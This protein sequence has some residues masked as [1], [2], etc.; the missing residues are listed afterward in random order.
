MMWNWLVSGLASGT[1][2]ILFDG[3]PLHP[4]TDSLWQ[5]AEELGVTVFG[6]SAKYLS[7]QQKAGVRVADRLALRPLR[8]ILS[9]GSPLA[10]ESFDYLRQAIKPGV[11]ISSISGGTDIVSCFALGNPLL[12]VRRGQLQCRGLGMA[13]EVFDR[14]GRSVRDQPGELVCTRSFPSMPVGFWNDPDGRRYHAAYFERFPGVWTHGDWTLLTREGGLIIEGRSDA[15]L[16]PGGVRIGT[17]EIYRQ[18]E[19]LPQIRESV[20][21]GQRWNDDVRVV[22]FVVLRE[23]QVLDEALCHAIEETL[24]NNASPRHV[25]ARILQVTDIPRT[26][27]G[28]ISELAVRDTVEGR[29]VANTE[30]L[31]NPQALAEYR[32]RTEL[33]MA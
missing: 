20:C 4:A 24:R 30:A 18:V 23:G 1:T 25:P 22:L 29:P 13:V 11:Q 21:V 5:M 8:T 32:D 33:T 6:T 9:T 17:A 19:R 26:R 15:T 7:A 14:E 12:P 31:L 10:P 2:L 27:S 3:N 28:K 16:N